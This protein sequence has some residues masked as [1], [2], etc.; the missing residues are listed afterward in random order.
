VA[1]KASA[2][3]EASTPAAAAA[4]APNALASPNAPTTR[5]ASANEPVASRASRRIATMNMPIGS[6]PRADAT[7]GP[8][9]PGTR[10]NAR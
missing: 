5:T 6:D 4:A 8:R 10:S 7:T 1:A 2:A 3:P 9:A